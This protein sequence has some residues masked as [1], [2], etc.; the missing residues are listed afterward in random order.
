MQ[1]LVCGPGRLGTAI[2]DA[3][4]AAGWPAP[5]LVGRPAGGA[6]FDARPP[7]DVV[8]DASGGHAVAA[9]AAEALAAGHRAFVIAATGWD[10]DLPRVRTLVLE[11]GAAAVVAPNLSLGAALFGRLVEAAA[12]W[13]AAAGGFEPSIVEWHRRGKADRPSGTARALARRVAA[14]DA[15]WALEGRPAGDDRPVLEV[16]GIRAGAAPGTHLVTFDGRGETV[17]LRLTA[18]DRGAYAEGAIA[19]ARW[20]ARKPRAP[21]LHPFDAVVDDLLSPAHS[22]ATA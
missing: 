12:G 6:R 18:R 3:A 20:L 5:R 13:Y 7:A 10:A 11:H 9:N 2:A 19:A 21:G 17:E 14:A 15:R 22:A 16:A 1:L 8:V 4:V